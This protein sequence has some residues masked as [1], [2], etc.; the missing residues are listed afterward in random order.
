METESRSEAEPLKV[1]TQNF[2]RRGSP[3]DELDP[4]GPS[5]ERLN[6]HGAR[7]GIQIQKNSSLNARRKYIEESFA[8]PVAGGASGQ[9][10]WGRER[11]RAERSGNNAHS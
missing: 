4:R 3:F 11:A 2:E 8:Q 7:A 6:A 1:A 5:A 10:W 9:S